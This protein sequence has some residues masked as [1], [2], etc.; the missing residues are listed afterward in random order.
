MTNTTVSEKEVVKIMDFICET[1][2]GNYTAEK[3]DLTY[4][5]YARMEIQE[6]D[7][8]NIFDDDSGDIILYGISY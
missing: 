8:A 4:I 2:E 5:V 7:S 6:S 3:P 1:K